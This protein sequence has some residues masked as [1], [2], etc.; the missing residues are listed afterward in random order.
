MIFRLIYVCGL[1]NS[2]ATN[3]KMNDIDLD[4][5]KIRIIHSKGDKDRIVYMDKSL[6]N[7]CVNATPFCLNTATLDCQ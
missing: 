4:E 2:E 7:L 1:R 3:I 5:G 6:V